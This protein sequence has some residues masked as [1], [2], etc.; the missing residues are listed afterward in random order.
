MKSVI[1]KAKKKN[2]KKPHHLVVRFCCCYLTY[3]LHHLSSHG[4]KS[5][6]VER[7]F[8]APLDD[9]HLE[10]QIFNRLVPAFG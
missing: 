7:F 9:S 10:I 2:R 1:N 4:F 6:K 5:N 8:L 3:S